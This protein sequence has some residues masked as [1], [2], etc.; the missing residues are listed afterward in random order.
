[1]TNQSVNGPPSTAAVA[2]K[3]RGWFIFLGVALII[4]GAV[5][6]AFPFFATIAAKTIIGWLFLI[7]GVIQVVHAFSTQKWSAFFLELIIGVLYVLAGGWM[8]FFPFAGII[9][10]TIFLAVFFIIEG[11]VEIAMGVSRSTGRR[12]GVAVGL[13]HHCDSGRL[14]D[15]GRAA[16]A[17]RLGPSDF[18]WASILS[19]PGSATSLSVRRPRHER[20]G[21][22]GLRVGRPSLDA[23]WT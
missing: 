4:I 2:S 17:P 3:H 23:A 9:T 6:I 14:L 18:S 20:S 11:V 8:A 1:M 21:G 10:L 13:R 5:A 12:L 19:S 7:G 22:S 16:G 15:S